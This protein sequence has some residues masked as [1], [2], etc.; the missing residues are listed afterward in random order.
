MK[1]ADLT[2]GPPANAAILSERPPF[3]KTPSAKTRKSIFTPKRD[4]SVRLKKAVKHDVGKG[5][6]GGGLYFKRFDNG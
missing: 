3:V 2:G 6:F 4:K 1:Q 5:V